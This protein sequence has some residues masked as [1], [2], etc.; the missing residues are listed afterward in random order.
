MHI[1]GTLPEPEDIRPFAADHLADQFSAVT[2]AARDF[3]DR[4]SVFVSRRARI[5]PDP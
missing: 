4:N 2:G 3:L 1:K 5:R